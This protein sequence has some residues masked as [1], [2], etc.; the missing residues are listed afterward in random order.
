LR[1]PP[2]PP[3]VNNFAA[4][5]RVAV[6]KMSVS[7]PADIGRASDAIRSA[8]A[9]PYEGCRKNTGASA[10]STPRSD[11]TKAHEAPVTARPR[12]GRQ[13]L[14]AR[15]KQAQA[16]MNT[17]H[18][19]LTH[20][21]GFDWAS[22]HHDVIIVDGTGQIVADFKIEHT[23][24]GWRQWQQ[25]TAAYPK[26]GVA[27]ETSFGAVVEQIIHSALTVYPV[28]PLSA[29]RYR[30][31]K[32]PSGTKTDHH[33]AWSL[34]DALRTDGHAWRALGPK[35]PI[36]EELRILCRDEVAL[37]E[38]R[39]A[40]IN[41]LR[42][43][44]REY[45]PVALE[46]FEDWT[47]AHAWAF[48]ER[49]P[50]ASALLKAGK[51]QWEKFLHSHKLWRAQTSEARLASFAKAGEWH[52]NEGMVKAKSL[53]GVAKARQLRLLQ[54]QLEEYRRRIAE[55]FASH[56]DSGLFGSLPGAG[57]KI[58][59]R[60]LSEMGSDRA[61]YEDAQG[62]QCVA[63]T[64]PVSYQSGKVHQ[65]RMRHACNRNLRYTMHLFADK[66]RAQCAWAATYYEALRTRGKSHAQ[67]LRN[68]GQRWLKIIWKMWQS[69]T[70]YDAEVHLKNQLAHGSW[71]LQAKPA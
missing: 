61:L 51:R 15:T 17:P 28:N 39:T 10:G 18:H 6:D 19:E 11:R 66:S 32:A 13:R 21:A 54:S 65:V 34:A 1:S 67:A 12:G 35:D 46:A 55:L 4:A 16:T 44:L 25:K 31:R 8:A 23:A 14:P 9:H 7:A 71:V 64:A 53:Y 33:D 27:I 68:L 59:P 42:Q 48:I 43:A 56:P 60:L 70:R 38:E 29:R 69:N 24:E 52:I 37:I 26:L 41:Q 57:P 5:P 3:L 22:D 58:G 36:L 62:L 30:E 45:Y 63:G 2:P 40:L 50:S 20:F 49:F 47:S